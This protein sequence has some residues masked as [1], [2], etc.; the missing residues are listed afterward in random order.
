MTTI[1][2]CEHK[3]QSVSY[4]RYPILA[5]DRR[6]TINNKCLRLVKIACHG[7]DGEPRQRSCSLFSE[8]KAA[9]R[10]AGLSAVQEL[11]L[12]LA[13]ESDYGSCLEVVLDSASHRKRT[14]VS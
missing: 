10:P 8:C 3:K 7:V 6:W 2:L 12:L 4:L 14:V 5:G 1:L 9:E 13:P 11:P